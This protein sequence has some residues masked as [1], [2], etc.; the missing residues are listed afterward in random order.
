MK[1]ANISNE[2]GYAKSK[3]RSGTDVIRKIN[4]GDYMQILAIDYLYEKMGIP[5]DEII[6][7]EYYDLFDYDGEY[8]VLPINF[9]FFNAYY[10]ERDLVF[11]PKVIPVFLGIHTINGN[12]NQCELEYLKRYSPIGCRDMQ[13]LSV[14]R[15]KN[16]D[17]YL[18]GCIS[19]VFPKRAGMKLGGVDGGGKVYLV[20]IPDSLEA[21]IPSE[22]AVNAE[23]LT[24]EF[25]GDINAWLQ[26]EH[27]ESLKEYTKKR[28]YTYRDTAALVVTSRL[29]C[30]APCIGMGI[31]VIFACEEYSSRYAWIG[32]F[33]PIYT[34][35]TFDNIEWNPGA[36]EFE[37]L[38]QKIL[39]YA[40]K[41][42][43][44]TRDAYL[45]RCEI[46]D[47]LECEASDK[48][49]EA[50][51][52]RLEKYGRDHWIEE[53]TFKYMVWGVTQITDGVCEYMDEAY[54]NATLVGVVDD[55]RDLKY[56]D[57]KTIRSDEIEKY[58]ECYFIATGNSSSS[59]AQ[60]KFAQLG[61]SDKLC[62]VFGTSHLEE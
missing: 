60:K 53:K 6:Y 23:R 3:T 40:I 31:P 2:R 30:A 5:E 17:A 18:Q 39:A 43:K 34:P 8:V 29:H 32:K 59:A 20:D 36:A 26:V 44:G 28:L 12:Y 54:P 41:R 46:S 11:S 61:W 13:S 48:Y 47:F 9:I 15:E 45:E 1:Y 52:W 21:H 49:K 33:I 25:Y 56:R 50:Y 27:C 37:S 16:I 57:L 42:I 19:T 22:I 14:L 55:Y 4:I 62:T 7:I 10:G 51:T 58:P 38:K 24:Q 35:D